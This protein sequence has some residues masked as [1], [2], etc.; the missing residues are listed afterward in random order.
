M[1]ISCEKLFY[2]IQDVINYG[3]EKVI[4]HDLSFQ[5]EEKKRKYY[6]IEC[7]DFLFEVR[8]TKLY[9]HDYTV[10]VYSTKTNKLL[11]KDENN[12]VILFEE[13]QEVVYLK[14]FIII[15]E[16]KIHERKTMDQLIQSVALKV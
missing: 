1:N 10:S 3:V 6:K 8:R 13:H 11:A 15:M 4:R 14:A 9:L 2:L 5:L 16:Q 12:R 7:N